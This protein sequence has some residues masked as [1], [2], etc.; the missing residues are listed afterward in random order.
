M[1]KFLWLG[2]WAGLAQAAMAPTRLEELSTERLVGIDYKKPTVVSFIQPSCIPCKR[3]LE[4]L[5]CLKEKLGD[6]VEVLAV[7]STGDS[8]EL[9]RSL[10]SLHLNFQVLKGTPKYLASFEAD[11]TPTPMTAVIAAGGKVTDRVLG[12]QSC[13]YWAE[14]LEPKK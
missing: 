13:E 8:A 10:K 11:Q 6:K 14:H 5:K 4:A 7:Q 3:Q 12:A 9:K 1:K 2:V